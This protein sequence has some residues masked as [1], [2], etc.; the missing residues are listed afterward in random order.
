MTRPLRYRS[1]LGHK[2]RDDPLRLE[3][4]LGVLMI[5]GVIVSLV[6]VL[7]NLEAP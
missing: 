2:L 1:E 4:V 7:F 3:D 5:V 6:I